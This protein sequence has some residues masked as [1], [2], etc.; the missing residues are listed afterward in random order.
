MHPPTHLFSFHLNYFPLFSQCCHFSFVFAKEPG[1]SDGRTRPPDKNITFNSPRALQESAGKQS[2]SSERLHKTQE[3]LRLQPQ[4][5][6]SKTNQKQFISKVPGM[7]T[8]RPLVHS[9]DTK[10][11]LLAKHQYHSLTKIFPTA[12]DLRQEH[13]WVFKLVHKPVL[14]PTAKYLFGRQIATVGK[15]INKV[16]KVF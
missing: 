16:K 9:T 10:P 4:G 12:A 14:V 5:W 15:E 8:R 11:Q 6:S 1:Q 2:G 13:F 3:F 7:P